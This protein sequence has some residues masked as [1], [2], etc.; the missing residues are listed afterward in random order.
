MFENAQAENATLTW[1]LRGVGLFIM[2]LGITLIFKPL[3][4][5]ADVVPFIGNLLQ[6]GIGAFALM[7]ALPLTLI[8][9]AIGWISYRPVLGISLLA[10]A[11]AAFGLIYFLRRK[12]KPAAA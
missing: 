1:I 10:A 12:K 11:A 7:F 6:M 8:T 4:V 5:I 2:W 3:V 9:I